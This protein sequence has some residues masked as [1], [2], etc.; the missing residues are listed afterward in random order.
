MRHRRACGRVDAARVCTEAFGLSKHER[1][2]KIVRTRETSDVPG[3]FVQTD[4]HPVVKLD[5]S[6]ARGAGCG[7]RERRRRSCLRDYEIQNLHKLTKFAMVR[8][9]SDVTPERPIGMHAGASWLCSRAPT[10]QRGQGK[11]DIGREYGGT[12][13]VP[14]NM[15]HGAG[16]PRTCGRRR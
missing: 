1:H 7:K 4:L 9:R 12:G 13:T 16:P 5:A 11:I 10:R 14:C 15:Q 6:C 2:R 3:Q 8:M